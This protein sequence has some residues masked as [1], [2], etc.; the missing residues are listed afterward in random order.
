MEKLNLPQRSNL[1]AKEKGFILNNCKTMSQREIAKRLNRSP[2]CIQNFVHKYR[3]STLF[4]NGHTK[5][6]KT[7]KE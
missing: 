2:T 7:Q 1:T 6:T 4:I 5:A 3:L